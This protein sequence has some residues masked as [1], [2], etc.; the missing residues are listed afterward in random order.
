MAYQT[1]RS[2]KREEFLKN[3]DSGETECCYIFELL[4]WLFGCMQRQNT[5]FIFRIEFVRCSRNA[6][7]NVH[8]CR[9]KRRRKE[10]SQ[11][12]H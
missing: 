8:A 5:L 2:S 1:N 12:A 10:T 11:T 4:Q 6:A 7:C 9:I 3:W